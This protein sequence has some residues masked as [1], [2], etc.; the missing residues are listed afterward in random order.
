M[1]KEN[2]SPQV[3]QAAEVG[4]GLAYDANAAFDA[5][6]KAERDRGGA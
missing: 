4:L 3:K 2:L 5:M 6:Q 1:S